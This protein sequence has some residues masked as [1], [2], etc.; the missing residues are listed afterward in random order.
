MDM[1]SV[2]GESAVIA[3]V[4]KKSKLKDYSPDAQLI[5]EINISLNVDVSGVLPSYM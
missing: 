5:R 3:T 2:T 4:Y 1:T